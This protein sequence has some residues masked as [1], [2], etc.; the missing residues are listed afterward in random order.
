MKNFLKTLILATLLMAGTAHALTFSANTSSVRMLPETGNLYVNG[1]TAEFINVSK[2]GNYTL[3]VSAGGTPL[4]GVYPLMVVA[5]DQIAV[6]EKYIDSPTAYKNFTF[7]LALQKGV[8]RLSLLFVNDEI[9][10]TEDRNIHLNTIT[11][12]SPSGT[13]DS[14]KSTLAVWESAQMAREDVVVAATDAAIQE[15]RVGPASVTVQDQNGNPLTGATVSIEQIDHDFLFGCNLMGYGQYGNQ[16]QNELYKSRFADV[17]NYATLS[18]Y[19]S[20]F[21]PVQGQPR[22]DETNFIVDWCQQNNIRMKAHPVLYEHPAALPS[23]MNG[24]SPSNS[25]Q[26]ARVNNLMSY[27]QGD[28][29]F[30]EVTNEPAHFGGL[31]LSTSYGWARNASPFANLVI[32]EFEVYS[33][34]GFR[35]LFDYLQQQVNAGTEFDVIGLQSHEPLTM[36]FPLH[37]VQNLLD[38]YGSLGKDIHITEFTPGSSGAPVEGATWYGTWTEAVQAEYAERFYRVAFAHPS[39]EAISWWDFSDL[40]AWAPSGGLLRADLSPKPAYDTIKSLITEEW[41]TSLNAQTPTTGTYDFDGFYGTYRVVVTYAG[42]TDEVEF[43]L[44]RDAENALTFT[45]AAPSVSV[46]PQSTTNRKPTLTGSVQNASAVKV[47]VN[48]SAYNATV[49]GGSWSVAVTTT[50]ADGRYDVK[51]EATAGNLKAVDTTKD[52]LVV[53]AT[54]PLITLL[55]SATIELTEGGSFVDPGATAVD[56]VDGDLSSKMVVKNTVN[57]TVPGTYQVSYEAQDLMGNK[58]VKSRTIIVNAAPT[59]DPEPEPEPQPTAI[60][61][62]GDVNRD[63]VINGSDITYITYIYWYGEAQ[64]NAWLVSNGQATVDARLADVDFSG[65]IDNWDAILTEHYLKLGAKA[66]NEWLASQGRL[67]CHAGET[68]F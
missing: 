62:I 22:Y 31:P 40:N 23:W 54:A 67:L 47:T 1:E 63:G 39:V 18:F 49:N 34:T 3:T 5:V 12:T 45:F 4:G 16:T 42:Q 64:L 41:H 2:N 60:G 50:L 37:R 14:T 25:L 30:W 19:W 6:A 38:Q 20:A 51:A 33:E 28:I 65:S 53:D 15:L 29:E 8:H 61:I 46:S 10:A 17:F 21:E 48:G 36:A 57:T 9:S 11:L 7:T 13:A 27:Y 55:G 58:A 43:N 26:Q 68:K 56:S 32:N 59:P 44:A 52:E 24:V 66:L 35:F